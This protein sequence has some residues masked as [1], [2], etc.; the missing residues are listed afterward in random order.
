LISIT[1]KRIAGGR[2]SNWLA[3]T[4]AVGDVLTLS[5]ARGQFV[6]PREPPRKLLMISA[7][8]GITPL[9]AMLRQLVAEGAA[10]EVAFM[11]FA[12][13]PRDIIF[14][15][16]L[17]RIAAERP[18]VRMS[19][20]VEEPDASWDGATGRFTQ[21]LLEQVAPDFRALDT[22]LCG[23]AP[24]MRAVVQTLERTA[25]D[26]SKL[27]MERFSLDFSAADFVEHGKV[28]RFVRSGC[29]SLA[30]GPRT[31]LE[32]AESVGVRAPSSCRTGSCGTC[33]CTKKSG[34]VVD[35]ATGKR[36]GSGVE[37]IYPCVSVACGVVEV[38][39]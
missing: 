5:E 36:S 31:I 39:L 25:A 30:S 9:M 8:S 4:L 15:Q 22:Y 23:P 29:E 28:V 34:V 1:V 24:F 2:V 20:S 12:R 17:A 35:V 3:D 27:H 14:R 37:L 26:L 6:L 38:D 19:L 10:S 13:S 32:Q 18:N 16:E 11:H 21:M 7:G 33:R